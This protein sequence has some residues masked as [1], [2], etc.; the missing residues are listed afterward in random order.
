M[1][2][3]RAVAAGLLAVVLVVT[4]ASVTSLLSISRTMRR[5]RLNPDTVQNRYLVMHPP[6]LALIT[7]AFLVGFGAAL[8]WFGMP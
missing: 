4:V 7:V 1:V 3:V 2:F 6:S 5:L 8:W